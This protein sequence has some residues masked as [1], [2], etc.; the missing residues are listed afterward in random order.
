MRVE[1]LEH[2]VDRG[3]FDLLRLRLAV[4]IL[5]D[6]GEHLAH[7]ALQVAEIS[8]RQD[9]EALRRQPHVHRHDIG[10]AVFDHD[11]RD[12]R[13]DAI[14]ASLEH[15]ARIDARRVEVVAVDR[16][17]RAVEQPRVGEPG[18]RAPGLHGEDDDGGDD[19]GEERNDDAESAV[20]HGSK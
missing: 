14:E 16:R 15:P 1:D 8:H 4:V 7:H 5:R 9:A 12:H 11:L 2:A 3:I 6:V 18:G 17:E 10:L 20:G 13:L 19:D